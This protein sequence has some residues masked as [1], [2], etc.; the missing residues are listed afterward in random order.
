MQATNVSP[1]EIAR[2]EKLA[3]R[4]WGE[5]GRDAGCDESHPAPASARP[6]MAGQAPRAREGSVRQEGFAS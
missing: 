6:W 5:P 4:W 1:D 2:F 3:A